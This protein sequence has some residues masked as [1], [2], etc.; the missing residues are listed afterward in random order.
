MDID[1]FGLDKTNIIWMPSKPSE[2]RLLHGKVPGDYFFLELAERPK[3]PLA[4][5]LG[6]WGHGIIL[7]RFWFGWW[8]GAQPFS[9]VDNAEI[10]IAAC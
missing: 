2:H 7:L 4:I 3:G 1:S 6:G 10:A 9:D 5:A 8:L